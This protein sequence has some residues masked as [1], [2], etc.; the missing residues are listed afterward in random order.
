MSQTSKPEDGFPPP[1]VVVMDANVLIDFKSKVG[2]NDQWDLLLRMSELVRSGALT[3]PKQVAQELADGKH[4]DAPGAWVNNAK[5]DVRHRQ[6]S[7]DTLAKVLEVAPEVVDLEATNE[8]E[9]AD[10][11]VAAMAVEIEARHN[12]CRVVV[13]TNDVVDRLPLKLSLLTACSR[14]GIEV[15]TLEQFIGWV[16]D[17]PAPAEP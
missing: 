14:L 7:E 5:R 10:P 12:G 16:K 9:V 4:P 1:F 13:A 17:G 11:Y 8:R 6:P 2:I 15:C 3:F